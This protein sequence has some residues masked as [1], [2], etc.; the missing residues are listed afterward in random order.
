MAERDEFK[1]DWGG[2]K[3]KEGMFIWCVFIKSCVFK[4][5]VS[6]GESKP[7]M[8]ISVIVGD[9]PGAK[10]PMAGIEFE[11]R[12]YLH[13]KSAGWCIYFLR[14]F[15]YPDELLKDEDHPIIRRKEVAG[16]WGKVLVNVKQ[17]EAYLNFDVKGFARL[18]G[19]D[20]L[21]KRLN[22]MSGASGAANHSHEET[23]FEAPDSPAVDLEA[24][25]KAASATPNL[26]SPATQ[27]SLDEM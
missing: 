19:D 26:E 25:V 1:P 13:Q 12:I 3:V 4:E 15:G 20:S 18:H 7:Y 21:E 9:P 24:D 10:D 5:S 2:P 27:D 11:F 22:T 6:G 23:S 14:K 16:L 8:L 17:N